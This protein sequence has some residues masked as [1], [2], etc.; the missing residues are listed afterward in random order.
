MLWGLQLLF[1]NKYKLDRVRVTTRLSL[2]GVKG[3]DRCL[4]SLL[5]RENGSL[6]NQNTHGNI[7]GLY[8]ECS[9]D[10]SI[11]GNRYRSIGIVM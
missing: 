4:E 1:G 10:R 2:V 8:P 3:Q 6:K 5:L 9:T 11:Y 7:Q